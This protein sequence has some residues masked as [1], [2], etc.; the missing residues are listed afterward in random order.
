[1]PI[2]HI[3]TAVSARRLPV[4]IP[5]KT[6]PIPLEAFARDIDR[7][8]EETG[9]TEVPRNVGTRRTASK[10]AL[11]KAIEDVGGKW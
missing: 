8:R 11:L 3:L 5:S 6:S 1:M 2:A 7:R 9:V 4:T 10:R